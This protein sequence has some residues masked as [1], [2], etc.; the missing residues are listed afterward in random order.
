MLFKKH[1]PQII[2]RNRK[3]T[4]TVVT[5]NATDVSSN[6]RSISLN[7]K[8]LDVSHFSFMMATHDDNDSSLTS[9]MAFKDANLGK[10]VEIKFLDENGTENHLFKGIVLN[11]NSASSDD[12]H[13]I[14]HISGKGLFCKLDGRLDC[15]S[16]LNK[17]ISNILSEINTASGTTISGNP[18]LTEAIYYTAQYNQTAFEFMKF[19]AIRYGEWMYYR[20]TE[21]VFGGKP[22]SSPI[23]LAADTDLTD[24]SINTQVAGT[25]SQ[26][27]GFDARTAEATTAS[28]VSSAPGGL[29]SSAGIAGSNVFSSCGTGSFASSTL[30]QAAL[31]EFNRMQQ[32][33]TISNSV[34]L[35]ASSDISGLRLGTVINITDTD[36]SSGKQFIIIEIHHAATGTNGYGNS[37]TAIPA[38]VTLPHYTNPWIFRNASNQHAV[39][40]ANADPDKLDRIKVWFPWMANGETTRWI[41]MMTP[42]T[43]ADKGFRWLPELEETVMVGFLDDNVDR[44]VVLG[45]VFDNSHK[46][47]LDETDNNLKLI[48]SRTQR[49][50]EIND[51]LGTLNIVDNGIENNNPTYPRNALFLERKNQEQIVKLSSLTRQDNGALISLKNEKELK[52]SL[53]LGGA[54]TEITFDASNSANGITMKIKATGNIE[55]ISEKGIKLKATENIEMEA[56]QEVIIKG[57]MGV[58]ME[59]MNI[60]A[61]A[62]ANVKLEATGQFEAKGSTAKLNGMGMASIESTG[63]TEVKGSL[64]KIN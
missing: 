46:S 30:R 64:V 50:I 55:I 25:T 31:D 15:K 22:S 2:L 19:M 21:L 58:K 61:K 27:T 35:N 5:L 49:R 11:I 43:G 14:Y 18:V 60:E 39:V 38:E 37:F 3:M 16:F 13:N 12:S 52:L 42:H 10:E 9:I 28:T 1:H 32:Q 41:K 29:L 24:I 7:E 4:I 63:M 20:G 45:A 54:E 36:D 47:N 8:M 40:K 62:D 59:G 48:G 23:N 51:D 56:T 57:T 17:S 6:V 44:P 26:A 53:K 34:F 33:A